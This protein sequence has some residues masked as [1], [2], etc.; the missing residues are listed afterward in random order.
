VNFPTPAIVSQHAVRRLPRS[1]LL[2]FCIT[3]SLAGFIGRGPWKN[4]DIAAFGYMQAL[5]NGHTSWL[6][7]LLAGMSPETDGLLPFWLGA[8]AI[9]VAP[10]WMNADLA[11]RVPFIGLLIV[12]LAGT[13]YAVYSLARSPRAQP[14]AFA[15]GGEAQPRDYARAIADGGLLA[16]V[17]C[18]GLAQLSHEITAY[19]TQLAFTTL[20]FFG[21]AVAPYRRRLATATLAIGLCGLVLS[22]A[23]TLA[24]LFGAGGTV[25]SVL[26]SR[27]EPGIRAPLMRWALMAGIVTIAA[28]ALAAVMGLW[29][30]RIVVPILGSSEWRDIARL[31]L[32]FTWPT[33]PLACWTL[34]R[35]RRQWWSLEI[36]RHVALPVW[37]AGVAILA[38]FLTQPADRALL[39]GLPALA[40]LAAFALPTLKRGVTAL[41]DWFTLLFFTGAAAIIWVVYIAMQTGWPRQPA[42]N[43]AKLAPGFSATFSWIALLVAVLATLAWASLVHWRVGRHR[44]AIWKSVVLPSAGAALAWVLLMTLWLPLLDYARSFA[45]QVAQARVLIGE[46]SC[47]QVQALSRAQIAAFEYHAKLNAVTT[48]SAHQCSVLL[49]AATGGNGPNEPVDPSVWQYAGSVTR[50]ADREDTVQVFHRIVA[51][52]R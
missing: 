26:E 29:H 52:H 34:W 21:L 8:W 17:A 3:Y 19:L 38:T 5:A 7:P 23:P 51:P 18:L 39:L 50:P 48:D 31:L 12:T 49:V 47:V 16:L 41:I 6:H 32:W 45:P 30:W 9:R 20:A 14:V 40:A 25:L 28:A 27:Q 46:P 13:W 33:W 44:S 35:W 10:G 24:L 36:N 2:L 42:A 37:F 11:A 1:A 43:V 22:G 4:A 15:F